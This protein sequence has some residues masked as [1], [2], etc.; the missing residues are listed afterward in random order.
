MYLNADIKI[1]KFIDEDN[2]FAKSEYGL[3]KINKIKS[4]TLIDNCNG[5]KQE[6]DFF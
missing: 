3:E 4:T 1:I 5:Y 6:I 2:I